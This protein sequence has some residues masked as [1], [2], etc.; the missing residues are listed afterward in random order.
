MAA[1]SWENAEI[2]ELGQQILTPQTIGT[3]SLR[4]PITDVLQFDTTKNEI[5]PTI[6][7][8][9]SGL[10]TVDGKSVSLVDVERLKFADAKIAFDTDGNAGDALQLLY[11]VSKDQ[12][13]NNDGVKGLAIELIDKAADRNEIVDYVMGVLAGPFWDLNDISSVLAKNVYGLEL[14]AATENLITDLMEASE[15]DVYDFFWAIAESET[16][17]SAIGLVGLSD[18]GIT[19]S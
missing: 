12:Y 5:F 19:Y 9:S 15:W 11:A 4:S 10:T 18:S 1:V 8:R 14:T 7:S 16:V 6:V 3:A 17:S 13:L 2:N